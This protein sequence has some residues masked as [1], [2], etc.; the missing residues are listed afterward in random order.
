[1]NPE[2]KAKIREI[3]PELKQWAAEHCEEGNYVIDWPCGEC[4]GVQNFFNHLE[5]EVVDGQ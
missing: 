3:L 1:M 4:G 2:L 5:K